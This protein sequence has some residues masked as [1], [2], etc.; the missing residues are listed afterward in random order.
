MCS[1]FVEL[2]HSS[3]QTN[4]F[5]F[6]PQQFLEEY[7]STLK[8]SANEVKRWHREFNLND[9]PDIEPIPLPKPPNTNEVALSAKDVLGK[10]RVDVL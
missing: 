3:A 5:D 2:F 10:H 6:F 8:I 7:D 4:F 1:I 9:V